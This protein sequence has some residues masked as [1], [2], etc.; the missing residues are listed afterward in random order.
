MNRKEFIEQLRYLLQD[1]SEEEREDALEYYENYF[2]EAGEDQETRV[3]EELESPEKV[4]A[5]I[6]DSVRGEEGE[7][8]YTEQGY[9]NRRYEEDAKVPETRNLE[10]G[11]FHFKGNRN[12][13]MVLLILI[14][15][16]IVSVCL[17]GIAGIGGAAIGILGGCIGI[18]FSILG[19]IIGLFTGGVATIVYAIV[20]MS[21]S[22]AEG[23]FFLG[24]GFVLLALGVLL[25]I[26]FVWIVM[27]LLPRLIRWIVGFFRKEKA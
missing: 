17:P 22:V 2:D 21:T 15:I 10:F 4:A 9:Y 20:Q 26:L 18:I 8:Q 23:L 7:A 11:K 13:N 14:A 25:C 12:R 3:I 24:V 6:R 16:G 1:I 19:G 5:I 27:D